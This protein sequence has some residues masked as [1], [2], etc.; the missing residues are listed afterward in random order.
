[1]FDYKYVFSIIIDNVENTPLVQQMHKISGSL[2]GTT[3]GNIS[4]CLSYTFYYYFILVIYYF[5]N[6]YLFFS[7][8]A[9]MSI[10]LGT[11]NK[12]GISCSNWRS[13]I[14]SNLSERVAFADITNGK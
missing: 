10:S 2:N 5:S 3:L 14:F 11:G 1:M 9:N 12:K 7:Y 6:V 13:T 4:N 8:L